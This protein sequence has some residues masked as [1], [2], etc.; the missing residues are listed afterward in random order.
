M[1]ATST[2]VVDWMHHCLPSASSDGC[3]TPAA[4]S[5]TNPVGA[6]PVCAA[7][8]LASAHRARVLASMENVRDRVRFRVA[9]RNRVELRA[10][11][12][13]LS[14]HGT[15]CPAVKG[16][17]EACSAS[18]VGGGVLRLRY[19]CA[20]SGAGRFGLR[21]FRRRLVRVFG[22]A[23]QLCRVASNVVLVAAL[24]G[25]AGWW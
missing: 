6:Q 23:E 25:L 12:R 4:A 5:D 9:E 8:G 24:A 22:V 11:R 16:A 15:N 14:S 10:W 18:G 19:Q 2:E 17:G 7:C 1:V 20:G 13:G 3:S 21:L